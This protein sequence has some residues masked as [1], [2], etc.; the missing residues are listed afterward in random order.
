[1]CWWGVETKE[2]PFCSHIVIPVVQGEGLE[3]VDKLV[4]CD[5]L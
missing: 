2:W 3:Q 4:V 1:M 5:I